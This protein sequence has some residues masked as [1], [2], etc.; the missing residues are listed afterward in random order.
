MT[1]KCQRCQKHDFHCFREDSSVACLRCL[2]DNEPCEHSY[3]PVLWKRRKGVATEKLQDSYSSSADLVK[4]I[5]RQPKRK[6][7]Q[8]IRRKGKVATSSEQSKRSHHITL[9]PSTT[10]NQLLTLQRARAVGQHLLELADREGATNIFDAE[11]IEQMKDRGF[12]TYD[13]LKLKPEAFNG[14]VTNLLAY[15][16][17]IAAQFSPHSEFLGT[18]APISLSPAD[19]F[20]VDDY[21]TVGRQRHAAVRTMQLQAFSLALD[22]QSPVQQATEFSVMIL[23]RTAHS[24]CSIS[25]APHIA[26]DVLR[27]CLQH[28]DFVWHKSDVKDRQELLRLYFGYIAQIDN[29]LNFQTGALLLTNQ[30]YRKYYQHSTFEYEILLHPRFML[31]VPIEG[32]GSAASERKLIACTECIHRNLCLLGSI[33]REGDE[34]STELLLLEISDS[35]DFLKRWRETYLAFA[36]K[37]VAP[38]RYTTFAFRSTGEPENSTATYMILTLY[39][40]AA[41]RWLKRLE[42]AA[43]LFPGNRIL[44][45]LQKQVQPRRDAIISGV[46]TYASAITVIKWVSKNNTLLAPNHEQTALN[47]IYELPGGFRNVA[48]YMGRHPEMAPYVAM[49]VRQMKFLSWRWF[50]CVEALEA[51]EDELSRIELAKAAVNG[52]EYGA[53]SPK[54]ENFDETLRAFSEGGG[55][56]AA[57]EETDKEATLSDF[58]L[59]LFAI[60]NPHTM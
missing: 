26:R 18:V 58:L 32:D 44:N 6:S 15:C 40:K 41:A 13:D 59:E 42:E 53:P 43:Q 20:P 55:Q 1:S 60:Y 36:P 23:L 27:L 10:S 52:S 24:F 49:V 31:D 9:A 46:L 45:E 57:N 4:D 30:H 22:W 54:L 47:A 12:T 2:D 48:H 19:D 16:F 29:H 56:F 11:L 33:L 50:S 35:L 28:F 25:R 51:F 8:K 3:R 5:M 21:R 39:F 37:F 14:C 17:G 34:S 38:N 7:Q